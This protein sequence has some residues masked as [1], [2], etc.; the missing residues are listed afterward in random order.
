MAT[1]DLRRNVHKN[2]RDRDSVLRLLKFVILLMYI[3]AASAHA[4]RISVVSSHGSQGQGWLFGASNDSQATQCWLAVPAHVI[5]S[6]SGGPAAP[7][8]FTDS[9]GYTGE[10]GTPITLEDVAGAKDILGKSVDLAFAKLEGHRPGGCL[11]RLGLPAMVYQSLLRKAPGVDFFDMLDTSF[12]V[13]SLAV[14]KV[15]V[16]ALGG[17]LLLLGTSDNDVVNAHFSQG[18]SGSIGTVEWQNKQYPFAMV[19]RIN[20]AKR[21][22]LAVRFDVIRS[23]FELIESSV[24]GTSKPLNNYSVLGL[25]VDPVNSS[26]SIKALMTLDECWR[27]K[28]PKAERFVELL[29]ET[30]TDMQALRGVSLVQEASCGDEPVRYSVDQRPDATSNWARVGECVS[31]EV[32]V[33]N[34]RMD[35]RTPRQ[36]KIRIGPTSEATISRLQLY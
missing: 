22:V 25:R 8:R 12:G 5:R 30:S 3:V 4:E 26:K 32:A 15:Q 1:S 31:T 24:V 36:L 28:P 11:S 16:D 34:C 21:E 20:A 6:E 33:N 9:K 35:L 14:R 7:F 27:A 17:G 19:S 10:S 2:T 18:L 29:I 13:F 23:M